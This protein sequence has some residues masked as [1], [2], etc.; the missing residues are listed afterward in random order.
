MAFFLH[1]ADQC[2]FWSATDSGTFTQTGRPAAEMWPVAKILWC[3]LLSLLTLLLTVD[4]VVE[5]LH[6]MGYSREQLEESLSMHRYDDVSATYHLLGLKPGTVR[7]TD[8]NL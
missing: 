6:S 1:A 3:I 7:C 2:S 4:S 8:T 5:I